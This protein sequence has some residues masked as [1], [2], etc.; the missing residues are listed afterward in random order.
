MVV[1]AN[2]ACPEEFDAIAE[3]SSPPDPIGLFD[4]LLRSVGVDD[5][6]PRETAVAD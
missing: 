3:G 4:D 2:H 1:L 5:Q 6:A